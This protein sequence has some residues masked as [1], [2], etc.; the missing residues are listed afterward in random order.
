MNKRLFIVFLLGFSSGLPLALTSS[1]LQAWYADAGMSVLATGMLS[2][3]GMPYVYRIAWGPVLDRYSLF[4][5]G[6]RRSWMIVMQL[7]LLLGFNAL[8]W[9]SPNTS[10]E[11]MAVL[12]FACACF[13]ATQ[14]VAIDAHRVEYLPTSEHGLGASL[15]TFGYRL[16]LLLAGGFALVMA[17]HFGWAFTYRLMGFLMLIGVAATL[18]SSEPSQHTDN[19]PS[20]LQ[21]FTGPIKELIARRGFTSLLL[22]IL[23]YKL[24]E[25]FTATTS[26]I[27]MPFL[28]QG[29]GFSID[30]IGY[31]N[32]MMGITSVLLGG[33]VAGLLLLRWSLYRAL[34]VFGIIQAL[35]NLLFIALAIVGK[36]LPLFA[37]AVVCDNFAAGMG[38]T[39][40]VAFF[41]RVVKQ[42][43]TATQ[44]SLLVAISALPR[45]FSGPFAAM[46]QMWLGWIGLYQLSFLLA[47]GFI[48][49]LMM[50][51]E[52]TRE[53]PVVAAETK[54]ESEVSEILQKN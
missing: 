14:D 18:W 34:M 24:G 12:A 39:A 23:F 36:N 49:F 31:V 7:A 8:A 30:T 32:K 28:I 33:L 5:L 22:F 2:L 17:K 16:A 6:K 1:T 42:P 41:M 3:V 20:F 29:L 10:P 21:A 4:S 53:L 11:L 43:Y 47:L 50:I 25:A 45:I 52:H 37:T 48:P 19:N 38:S 13:S 27:V 26:G 46:L 9:L 35:T 40:L 54:E 44:F 15:A 51:R